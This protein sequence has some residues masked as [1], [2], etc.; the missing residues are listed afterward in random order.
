SLHEIVG[1]ESFLAGVTSSSPMRRVVV[2]ALCGVVAGIGWWALYRF[3]NPLVSLAAAIKK[4]GPAMPLTETVVHVVLQIVTVALGSPL[5]RESAPRQLGGAIAGWISKCAHLNTEDRRILVACGAGAGLAA[6]YNIPLGGALFTL[7]VLIGTFAFPALIPALVTSVIAAVVARIGLGNATYY[8]LPT[9][10]VSFSLIVWSIAAGPLFGF[11]AYG[12]VRGAGWARAHAPSDWRLVLWCVPIFV[13]IG[14]LAIP[15]PF[16]LGNG[17]GIVQ[18]GLDSDLGP[19]LAAMLF[20]LKMTVTLCALR[21]GAEGGLLTPSLSLG[22]TLGTFLCGLWGHV[23]SSGPS[24]A[25]AIVGATA[26]LA[27]SMKMPITAI[28]L[29]IELAHVNADFIAPLCFAVV[30]SVT[31]FHLLV[32]HLSQPVWSHFHED[33]PAKSERNR[34]V[35]A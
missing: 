7:E 25:F 26:F 32:Q 15:F 9:G 27:A 35:T 17:R 28:V 30:G 18:T 12:F 31:V 22:A 29:V 6:V 19:G 21:A 16:L 20:G 1:R 13:A 24:G 23:W 34:A 2:L 4:N 33:I 5:G 10:S 3:G 8:N 14:L 11:C